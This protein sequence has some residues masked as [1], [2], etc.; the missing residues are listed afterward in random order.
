MAT[1][2]IERSSTRGPGSGIDDNWHVVVLN[3]DHNTFDGVARAL[4]RVLPGVSYERGMALAHK[5]HNTGRATVWSGPREPAELYWE[6][7]RAA[8]LTMAPLEQG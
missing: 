8:G 5:I 7:L 3:D 6:Q 1:L 4:S 2:V